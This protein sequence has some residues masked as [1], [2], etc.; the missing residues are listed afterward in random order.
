MKKN[1]AGIKAIEKRK[2]PFSGIFLCPPDKSISHRAL[3]LSACAQ[4]KNRIG[5]FLY[6]QDTENTVNCLEKF[7]VKFQLFKDEIVVDSPGLDNFSPPKKPLN[8]GNSATLARLLLGLTAGLPFK[9]E[10]TGDKSLKKRDMGR[11]IK[12]LSLMGAKI[13]GPMENR[14]PLFISP[15]S[16]P[17]SQFSHRPSQ[18][19]GYSSFVSLPLS[20]ISYHSP[21]PSAQLKSSLLFAS[22][23]SKG[24][25]R[26]K[27]DYKSRDHTEILFEYSGIHLKIRENVI[28]ISGG[29]RPK[30]MD[31][32]VP[33]DPSSAAFLITAA[34]LIPDSRIK[35]TGICINPTRMGFFNAIRKMGAQFEISN[36]KV[37]QGEEVGDISIQYQSLAGIDITARDIPSIIDELPL[38]ALLSCFAQGQTRI[39]GAQELRNK[40]SDRISG[41]V[42]GLMA[43]G[44]RIEE[45]AD[46]MIISHSPDLRGAKVNSLGDHRLAMTFAIMGM[47][48]PGITKIQ[49]F[50]CTQISFPN[51][52]QVMEI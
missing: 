26:L 45:L 16:R 36:K 29:Q 42:K 40:E 39:I 22:F 17:L 8:A 1:N 43:F 24:E 4:G 31:Y 44:A 51:F 28:T 10:I 46:G 6:S 37:F 34:L 3:I 23:W 2:K 11:I 50:D 32:F 52:S 20:P 14:L 18:I 30:N 21:I 35:V 15:I 47:A 38:I 9:L 27:E 19:S 41:T 49:I 33:G 5:N 12:P 7:N 13:K 25:I 48:V